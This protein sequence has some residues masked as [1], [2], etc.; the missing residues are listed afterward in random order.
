MNAEPSFA[1]VRVDQ[2]PFPHGPLQCSFLNYAKKRGNSYREN[3]Q[4]STKEDA[5]SFAPQFSGTYICRRRSR[6]QENLKASPL[7]DRKSDPC[8]A[9]A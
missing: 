7:G 5:D 1:H 2:A 3:T 9:A 4:L 6:L 8:H